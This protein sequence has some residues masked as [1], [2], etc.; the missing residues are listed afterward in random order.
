MPATNDDCLLLWAEVRTNSEPALYKLYH[1]LYDELYRYGI[2]VC[3][4]KELVKDSINTLFVELWQK[5]DRL[6]DL[7]NVKGYVFIWYKRKVFRNVNARRSDDWIGKAIPLYQEME[8]RS[9]EEV[10]VALESNA[11]RREKIKKALDGLT[12]RQKEF[13]QMRF[14]EDLSYEEI[15]L[16][17]NTTVRTVYNTIHVALTKLKDDFR[18]AALP[19]LLVAISQFL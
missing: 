4:D 10:L 18:D 15:S 5:R 19:V 6:P 3:A 8:V 17:T 9:Y 1:I 12:S 11:I 2:H 16:K 13:I 7:E 14:Y